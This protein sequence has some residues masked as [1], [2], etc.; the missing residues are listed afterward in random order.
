VTSQD[1]NPFEDLFD[2][3][4]ATATQEQAAAETRPAER[5]VPVGKTGTL[6][7]DI[8]TG[9]ESTEVLEAIFGETFDES[10]TKGFDLIGREFDPGSVKLGNMKDQAKI[11]EK[12][13]AKRK[14]HQK[15]VAEATV[16]VA[17]AREEAWLRFCEKAPLSPETGRVL[18]IG[19]R[20]EELVDVVTEGNT[21]GEAGVINDFWQQAVTVISADGRLVGHNVFGF[22]LPFLV[23]RSWLLGIEIP[24]EVFTFSGRWQWNRAFMDTMQVWACGI[25]G[26]RVSLDRV[27]RFFNKGGKS[28][29]GANFHRLYHGTPEEKEE[30]I[31][32][33]ENDLAMTWRVG[34]VMGVV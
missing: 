28:G 27:C 5:P 18:A 22:D 31:K 32:Y 21:G 3:E 13:E 24:P 25:Y 15:A 7:F 19:T 10:K 14:E 4:E 23:R 16:A 17:R 33:L 30:A 34:R 11:D 20:C 1:A 29:S 26:E 8:E 9:P 12:I 6:V 2:G